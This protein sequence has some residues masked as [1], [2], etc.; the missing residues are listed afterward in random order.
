[1]YLNHEKGTKIWSTKFGRTLPI[2][3]YR[4]YPPRHQTQN[5]IKT[6]TILQLHCIC[7]NKCSTILDYILG[8]WMQITCKQTK[9]TKIFYSSITRLAVHKQK[10]RRVRKAYWQEPIGNEWLK[11]TRF[12]FK[13]VLLHKWVFT[14][15]QKKTFNFY[16][17]LITAWWVITTRCN[18]HKW[19]CDSEAFSFIKIQGVLL[20][21][22]V[23]ICLKKPT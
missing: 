11:Q 20:C 10:G 3:H 12:L 21:R 8:A 23:F 1:M 22:A 14:C 4:E 19:S 17:Y 5:S 7:E 18:V 2:G 13:D 16:N 9:Q 15:L 6:E